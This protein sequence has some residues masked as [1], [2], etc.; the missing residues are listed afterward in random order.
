M[1]PQEALKLLD[2]A[3]AALNGSREVHVRLAQA[4]AILQDAISTKEEVKG[5]G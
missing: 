2:Q 5:N 3:A 1:T 4:V